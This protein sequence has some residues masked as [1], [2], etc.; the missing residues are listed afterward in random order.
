M[1]RI[2]FS[3]CVFW[4]LKSSKIMQE[5]NFETDATSWPLTNLCWQTLALCSN[6]W[7]RVYMD[8]SSYEITGH[9]C[10]LFQCLQKQEGSPECISHYILNHHC[11]LH[12]AMHNA[13]PRP[14]CKHW[15]Q[16]SAYDKHFDWLEIVSR[17]NWPMVQT[18]AC[19]SLS[20]IDD[21]LLW[22]G[23]MHFSNPCKYMPMHMIWVYTQ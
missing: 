19:S 18:F 23:K 13:K 6:H 12:Y 16:F 17:Y 10:K 14:L 7:Y 8:S 3:S 5:F 4:T 9:H 21:H 1:T 11:W 15:K 22:S 2:L 20:P